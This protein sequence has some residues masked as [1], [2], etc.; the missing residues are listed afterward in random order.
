[1]ETFS[2]SEMATGKSADYR[3]I[4]FGGLIAGT[5]DLTSAFIVTALRGGSHAR[6]L[7]GIAS[8]LLG[9]DS[10]TGGTA[11]AALG[12]LLHF[13]IAFIWTI[14]FYLASR[15]IKFLIDQPIISGV[16]YG[17]VVYL[18][19]YYVIVPLSAAPFQMPHTPDAIARDV[20][21]HIICIGLPIA[22]V[23]RRYSK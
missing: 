19:M 23:V 17:V 18:L 2:A 6:M 3:A 9:A 21:I 8:G 11:T 15:K 22:L 14:V 1:M 20:F 4:L 10:F 16:L 12:V 7:Q 13:T 5:L